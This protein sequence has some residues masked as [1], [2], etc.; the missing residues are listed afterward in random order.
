[1][2]GFK[3]SLGGTDFFGLPKIPS[4]LLPSYPTLLPL[5]SAVCS[6]RPMCHQGVFLLSRCPTVPHTWG[7]E[8]SISTTCTCSENW[9]GACIHRG[10]RRLEWLTARNELL[11]SHNAAISP[12]G[13]LEGGRGSGSVCWNPRCLL[14]KKK[15]AWVRLAVP[16][17]H[18]S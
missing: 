6:V 2:L 18:W 12:R 17:T 5:G 8:S 9:T 14:M 11:V 10:E 7:R 13:Q 15:A 1:M 3:V 4:T 16:Y